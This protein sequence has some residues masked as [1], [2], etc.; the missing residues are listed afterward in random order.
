MDGFEFAIE[1]VRTN[2]KRSISIH[3]HGKGI[4]I[5]VPK[6]L[7]DSRIRS[8]LKERSPWII[9]KLKEKS[10]QPPKKPKQY[11]NGELFPYLGK[12]YFL[13][14]IDGKKKVIALEKEFFLVTT[15][16]T[17]KPVEEVI[18]SQLT[19]WYRD[20]A[21]KHLKECTAKWAKVIGVEPTT[22]KIKNYKARWGS[23]SIKGDITYNWQIIFAPEHIIDYVVVH[24]L[25][26]IIEHNHSPRYWEKVASFMPKW[27]VSRDWLKRNDIIIF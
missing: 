24:E 26:H 5:R 25:C 20:Q 3:M 23:C 13:K 17:K 27:K 19:A 8:I 9:K 16:K 1:V 15:G 7:S 12:N 11:V 22:V 2:R 4:R 21:E 18:K 6:F 10:G 14:I